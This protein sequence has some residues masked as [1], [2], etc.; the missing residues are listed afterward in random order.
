MQ[1]STENN[2]VDKE[3]RQIKIQHKKAK[4]AIYF[5]IDYEDDNKHKFLEYDY[6]P[7]RVF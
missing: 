5:Q 1:Q 3:I 4:S 6:D 7:N 2:K